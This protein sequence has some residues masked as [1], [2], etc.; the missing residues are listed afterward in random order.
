[1]CDKFYTRQSV[2][3]L[4]MECT[5]PLVTSDDTCI[6]PSAGEGSFINSLK[7][8]NCREYIFIDVEPEDSR[9]TKTDFLTFKPPK[10]SIFIGNPPFGRQSSLAKKFIKR[11]CE[12]DARI[13]AFILPRSF[14]KFS[15]HKCFNLQ[16]HLLHQI[17]L[18]DDSFTFKGKNTKVPCVFQIWIK[19]KESR[20]TPCKLTPTGWSFVNKDEHPTFSFR[21][22]GSQAGKI[23][24]DVNK[25]PQTHYFI[26]TENTSLITRASKISWKHENT[27]GPHSIGKQELIY[28]LNRCV[29]QPHQSPCASD[30]CD[31]QH[32]H[33]A[34]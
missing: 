4:C 12:Y 7:L 5:R 2:V 28:Q 15:M 13:I 34:Q 22:V 17:D 26:K 8:L 23:D 20:E 9:V 33:I 3:D 24:T 14:K 32:H 10:N 1:M 18:P 21:R 19:Q 25:C 6:E 30:Q 16:Y 11:A 29:L 31:S 27:V